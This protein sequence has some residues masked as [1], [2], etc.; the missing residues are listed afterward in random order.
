MSSREPRAWV[1]N[2]DAEDELAR[3]GAHTPSA[4]MLG[5]I[6]SLLPKLRAL[7]G[8]EDEVLFPPRGA[9]RGLRGVAWCPTRWALTQMQRAGV[10]VPPAPS[11]EILRR[12]NHRQFSHELH[13]SL[14]V[15][16]FVHTLEALQAHLARTDAL[17]EVSTSRTW[18]LKRPLGFTGRGRKKLQTLSGAEL[19]WVEASLRTGD[20]LQLEPWV[21][22]VLDCGLH[23]LLEPSGRCTFGRLTLQQIDDTGAWSS[24]TLAPEGTLTSVEEAALTTA[25]DRAAH[26]LHA[27]GYFGPFGLDAYRWRAPDGALHFQ[28]QSE[29]NA[30]Y[31]MGWAV[32]MR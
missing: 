23:G 10:V 30:R 26:A 24:T 29:I 16:A 25:V 21:D 5:R 17:A 7:L 11:M 18:L 27:A 8:P 12:V 22:R 19:A 2:L 9:V 32:G 20:G 15:T 3:G 6:D 4:A 1:F 13:Q 31:S 14:P 28:P